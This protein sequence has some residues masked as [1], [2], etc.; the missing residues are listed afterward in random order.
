VNPRW[1]ALVDDEPPDASLSAP[2][3]EGGWL[4]VWEDEASKPESAWRVDPRVV[5]AGGKKATVALAAAPPGVSI[6]FDD[7]A[8][9]GAI[10]SALSSEPAAICTT[11][12]SADGG[13]AGVLISPPH[14]ATPFA[15]IFPM[16]TLT[17]GAGVLSPAP[18]PTGPGTQR[19]G[20]DNPWPYETKV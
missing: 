5:D 17:V 15:T 20:S 4:A 7:P 6:P 2:V 14:L 9:T 16:R 18:W 3:E 1:I 8:V 13:Y 12:M 19:Y 11:L 10:R